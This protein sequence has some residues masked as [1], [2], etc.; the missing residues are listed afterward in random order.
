MTITTIIV[1]AA[2]TAFLITMRIKIN[3]ALQRALE[4]RGPELKSR[5]S[6]FVP[7]PRWAQMSLFFLPREMRME[8]EG[9]I[10]EHYVELQRRL[11]TR[12]A[13]RYFV[14]QSLASIINALPRLLL[15]PFARAITSILDHL[16][17]RAGG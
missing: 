7:P 13:R 17:W 12:I 6:A 8:V 14:V 4:N 1:A 2:C 16:Y 9:D 5:D 10:Y 15:R 3:L 11:G